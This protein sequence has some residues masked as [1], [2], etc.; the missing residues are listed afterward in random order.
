MHQKAY[1]RRS[2]FMALTEEVV[3]RAIRNAQL[4]PSNALANAWVAGITGAST[5]TM[6]VSATQATQQPIADY[7]R[8]PAAT[9]APEAI[10][11]RAEFS[12]LVKRWRQETRL[13]SSITKTSMHPS[14]QAIIGMGRDALPLIFEELASHSGHWFWALQAITR[15]N[16]ASGCSDFED[17]KCAWLAW[18]KSEQPAR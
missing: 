4:N 5:Y 8:S 14:Y 7:G 10:R 15:Q 13:V 2:R 1:E 3:Q 6:T 18:W 12:A 17:A 9:P 11:L 16:P